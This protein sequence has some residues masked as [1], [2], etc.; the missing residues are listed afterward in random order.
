MAHHNLGILVSDRR[1]AGDKGGGPCLERMLLRSGLFLYPEDIVYELVRFKGVEGNG[2]YDDG[3][4]V[5]V[6]GRCGRS[7]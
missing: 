5:N 7:C 1:G 4:V 6:A 2:T 3:C